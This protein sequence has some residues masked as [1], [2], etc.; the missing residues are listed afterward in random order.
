VPEGLSRHLAGDWF[1]VYSAGSEATYVRPEVILAMVEVGADISGQGAMML[2]RLP[3]GDFRVRDHR[4]RRRQ[5][6]MSDL[7]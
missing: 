4:L 6:V 1:G 7:T 3:G 5:R 2:G